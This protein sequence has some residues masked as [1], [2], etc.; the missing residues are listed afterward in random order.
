ML[1]NATFRNLFT[2]GTL[3]LWIESLFDSKVLLDGVSVSHVYGSGAAIVLAHPLGYSSSS[4]QVELTNSN[5]T[6]I[7]GLHPDSDVTMKVKYPSLIFLHGL[8]ISLTKVQ[9]INCT[10]VQ[11]LIEMSMARGNNSLYLADI[12]LVDN[13]ASLSSIRSTELH[14]ATIKR[15]TAYN[16]TSAGTYDVDSPTSAEFSA[17]AIDV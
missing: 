4:P 3:L 10:L 5:F 16:N 8:T 6:D 13:A 12:K 7:R 2:N 14:N 17:G 9:M 11:E 15:V 1:K